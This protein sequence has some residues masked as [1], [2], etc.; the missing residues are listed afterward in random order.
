MFSGTKNHRFGKGLSPSP[1]Q[2]RNFLCFIPHRA[3]FA[4][5]LNVSNERR[6]YSDTEAVLLSEKFSFPWTW[7]Y[8]PAR[9]YLPSAIH[10]NQICSSS[11]D[12]PWIFEGNDHAPNSASWHSLL[13]AEHPWYI[14]P[15]F[16]WQMPSALIRNKLLSLIRLLI[17]GYI[18][19]ELSRA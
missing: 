16:L 11:P 4:L 9:F 15:F 14:K 10:I 19:S 5:L 3:L 12:G 13:Q 6:H 18:N 17:N 1:A 8:L 2:Y 7:V